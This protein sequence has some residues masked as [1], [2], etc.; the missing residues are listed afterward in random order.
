MKDIKN[1][2][3]IDDFIAF[4]KAHPEIKSIREFTRKFSTI[5]GRYLYLLHNG[6]LTE[7]FPIKS[8]RLNYSDNTKYNSVSDFQ[9]YI[10]DNRIESSLEFRNKN[11][12]LYNRATRLRNILNKLLYYG[13]TVNHRLLDTLPKIQKF[14]FE[15]YISSKVELKRK[16]VSIYRNYIRLRD[17]DNDTIEFCKPVLESDQERRFFEDLIKRGVDLNDIVIQYSP[18]WSYKRRY[19]FLIKSKKVIIEIHGRHHFNSDL[20]KDVWDCKDTLEIDKYKNNLAINNGY[21]IMY[22]T[23]NKK[24]YI[25]YGY[26]DKVYTDIE[27]LLL[28]IYKEDELVNTGSVSDM[29]LL[30]DKQYY[31][32]KAKEIIVDEGGTEEVIEC[33]RSL[34]SLDDVN[35]F[36]QKHKIKSPKKLRQDFPQ[37]FRKSEKFGWINKL[38]YYCDPSEVGDI[39]NYK[40]LEDVNN[41]I[42]RL[43][44]PNLNILRT[45]YSKIYFKSFKNG[46]LKD[47][48]FYKEE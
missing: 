6:L 14:I 22:F 48:K 29:Y 46:W 44:I 21:K 26:F 38:Y 45:K 42:Q 30:F 8:K 18:T 27:E 9:K 15:N 43:K 17:N 36:L 40:C 1:F 37:V 5:Y 35:S 28:Q 34:R 12:P 47:I 20:L 25:D 19:D 31:L 16:H 23:Y 13:K 24:E 33:I 11:L 41:L 7:P 2:N 10:D 32:N 39:K 3:T 4:V